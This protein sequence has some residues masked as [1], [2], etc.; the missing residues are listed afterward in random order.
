[1]PQR[2]LHF[3]DALTVAKQL[4]EGHLSSLEVTKALLARI[5]ERQE[6]LGAYVTVTED[7]ALEQ[8]TRADAELQRGE[9]RSALHGVPVAVKDLFATR[10]ITTT[11]GMALY[12]NDKPDYNATVV[13]RLAEA[14]AVLLGK[15]KLTEGAFANH[16]PDVSPPVNVWDANC[17]VGASSSGSGVATSAGLCFASL[18]T[19]TGGSIRFPSA[20]NGIVGL[21][22]T[23]GRVS[24][25]GAFPL[26][27]SLDHIGPM[28]RSVA[29]AA[30]V[31]RIIAGPDPK[32]LTSSVRSVPDYLAELSRDIAGLKIGIDRSYVS[33]HTDP[34]LT[35]AV[36]EVANLLV[37]MGCET[38]DVT[39]PFAETAGGWIVTTAVEALDAHRATYPSQRDRYGSLRGLLDLGSTISAQ[40]YMQLE[41]RRRELVGSL[42][43][44]FNYCD[45]LLCPSMPLYAPPR[46]GEPQMEQA[47]ADLAQTMKFTAPFDYSGNPTLSLP[48]RAGSKRIPLG[49]QL[50]GRPFEEGLL[51]RAGSAIESERGL[52]P[53]PE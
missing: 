32:D 35:E 5:R 36:G 27:Y 12:A 29:D 20:A 1:M 30:A 9:I 41:M 28:T 6:R 47:E 43:R 14:G 40:A 22:P 7:L 31:L 34:E 50:V 52:V 2:P 21:K 8:A 45:L 42:G 44:V 17:W 37:T 38:L 26:A 4:H 51:L 13:E 46:E 23:R 33:D 39:I 18:G 3:Q 49:I 10:G 24:R 53:Y 25:H 19:D 16:H 11:N 15:L 48:W